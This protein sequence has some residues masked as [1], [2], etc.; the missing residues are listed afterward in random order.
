M[1][2]IEGKHYRKRHDSHLAK[3][4]KEKEIIAQRVNTLLDTLPRPGKQPPIRKGK[5]DPSSGQRPSDSESESLGND[6][7]NDE[8][9]FGRYELGD[10]N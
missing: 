4:A 3:E 2:A 7:N 5:V 1:K 10:E 9:M 8:D 6:P